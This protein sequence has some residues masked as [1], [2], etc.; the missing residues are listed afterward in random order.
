MNPNE[1]SGNPADWA[2]WPMSV[3]GKGYIGFGPMEGEP[4]EPQGAAQTMI[5]VATEGL[6]EVVEWVYLVPEKWEL[7]DIIQRL[8]TF[9]FKQ[10]EKGAHTL[11]Y[12]LEAGWLHSDP[13]DEDD[14][15][16]IDWEQAERNPKDPDMMLGCYCAKCKGVTPGKIVCWNT[17]CCPS[18]SDNYEPTV[19]WDRLG[20]TKEEVMA[21]KPTEFKGKKW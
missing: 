14:G 8:E 3:D 15:E 19:H 5:R 16:P 17:R 18:C 12:C 1:A 2:F 10:S 4:C 13:D 11:N 7:K 9:G 21:F 20:M 6:S